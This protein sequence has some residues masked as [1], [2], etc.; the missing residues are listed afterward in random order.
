VPI[1]ATNLSDQESRL[2]GEEK[3]LFLTFMR[4]M[5]QWKPEDRKGIRDIIEDEWL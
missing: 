5:L 2:Q 4:K 3:A 1:T